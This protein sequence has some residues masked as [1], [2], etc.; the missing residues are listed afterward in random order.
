MLPDDL[1]GHIF[2]QR[3]AVNEGGDVKG[4]ILYALLD[5]LPGNVVS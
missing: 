2:D 4:A 3:L 1:L 5:H